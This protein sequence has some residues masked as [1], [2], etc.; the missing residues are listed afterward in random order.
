MS[1]LCSCHI[2]PD[3]CEWCRIQKVKQVFKS[4]SKPH[5]IFKE[6]LW[7]AEKLEAEMIANIEVAHQPCVSNTATP[8]K[9]KWEDSCGSCKF[10]DTKDNRCTKRNI[11]VKMVSPSCPQ[12][13]YFA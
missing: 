7:M 6:V 2:D 8:A 5:P 9:P 3:S 13:R 11:F 12:W 4:L 1:N 10:M